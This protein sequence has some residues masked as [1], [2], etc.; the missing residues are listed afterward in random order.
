MMKYYL[1]FVGL[2]IVSCSVGLRDSFREERLTNIYKS[3]EKENSYVPKNAQVLAYD[4]CEKNVDD[5][6]IR[7][8]CDLSDSLL[9]YILLNL[10][11]KEESEGV[12]SAVTD[13]FY[14][15]VLYDVPENLMNEKTSSARMKDLLIPRFDKTVSQNTIYVS[16]SGKE[17]SYCASLDGKKCS[18]LFAGIML[19]E[20][21][22]GTVF[23]RYFHLYINEFVEKK[24]S[25]NDVV[26]IFKPRLETT[27]LGLS[28]NVRYGPMYFS[29]DGKWLYEYKKNR[30]FIENK[31]L[32]AVDSV[33][34]E[35]LFFEY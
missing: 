26:E 27:S 6:E 35:V 22:E 8:P 2:L 23:E 11:S 33:L 24:L 9:A 13:L 4:I 21:K 25:L 17:S 31:K 19:G 14:A 28:C 18:Y 3:Y 34:K 20:K 5:I 7:Y 29:H 32:V 1:M 12:K 10:N 16:E 15:P 30:N